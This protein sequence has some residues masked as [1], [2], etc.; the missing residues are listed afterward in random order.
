MSNSHNNIIIINEFRIIIK[1]FGCDYYQYYYLPF[2]IT[3]ST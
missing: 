3:T 2:D 1:K